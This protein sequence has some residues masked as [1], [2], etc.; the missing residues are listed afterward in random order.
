MR[1]LVAVI[2]L[3]LAIWVFFYIVHPEEPLSAGETS[4][5]VALAAILTFSAR[6]IWTR[7]HKPKAVG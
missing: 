2:M 3:A 5:I 4:V 7:L 6:A 1:T